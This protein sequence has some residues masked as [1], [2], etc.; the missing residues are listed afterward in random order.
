[1]NEKVK[2]G[3]ALLIFGALAIS[4]VFAL[5]SL[6]IEEEE[7]EGIDGGQEQV[8]T[9]DLI[10]RAGGF[11]SAIFLISGIIVVIYYYN[12]SGTS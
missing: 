2:I 7:Q 4:V 11:C 5:M 12:R 1:M 9:V 3:I 8:T 10:A 6:D